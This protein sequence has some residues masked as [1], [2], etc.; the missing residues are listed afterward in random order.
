MVF[1]TLDCSLG[2]DKF[3]CKNSGKVRPRKIRGPVFPPF[4]F[5][6]MPKRNMVGN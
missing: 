5:P 6:T 3:C 2:F 1:N 4:I